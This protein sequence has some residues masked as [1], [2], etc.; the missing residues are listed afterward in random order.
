MADISGT[1]L[2]APVVPFTTEDSYPTHMAQ[3]GKGG[4]RSVQTKAELATIPS[5]RLE[6][7]MVA[8]VITEHTPYVYDGSDWKALV[9]EMDLSKVATEATLIAG[10]AS[11]EEKIENSL[12]NEVASLATTLEQYC[13][14][15]HPNLFKPDGMGVWY[16][17]TGELVDG[18]GYKCRAVHNTTGVPNYISVHISTDGATAFILQN[19]V[20]TTESYPISKE[21]IKTVSLTAILD[22]VGNIQ[23]DKSDLAK[24]GENQEATNSAILVEMLKLSSKVLNT[25]AVLTELDNGKKEMVASLATKNVQSS[26]DKTLSAIASDVRSIAQSPIYIDGGEM[27]EKQLFGAPTDKT[28]AYEQPNAP[29]WNLSQVMVNILSDG[30]FLEYGGIVLCEYDK[31]VTSQ[32]FEGASAGGLYFTSEGKIQEAL[33]EYIWD[34]F[35]NGKANRWVAIFNKKEFVNITFTTIANTPLSIHIGRKVGLLTTTQAGTQIREIICTEGNEYTLTLA[36]TSFSEQ[37]AFEGI[38]NVTQQIIPSNGGSSTRVIR[39]GVGDVNVQTQDGMIHFNAKG[40]AKSIIFSRLGK[41]TGKLLAVSAYSGSSTTISY[42]QFP[43]GYIFKGECIF[44]QFCVGLLGE[45][46]MTV[47][48]LKEITGGSLIYNQNSVINVGLEYLNIPDLEVLGTTA[49]IIRGYTNYQGGTYKVLKKI[50]IPK[51]RQANVVF[52]V[53]LSNN[54]LGVNSLIDVVV[55]AMETSF[56]LGTWRPLDVLADADKVVQLN[57]N[58]REHIAERITDRNGAEP[59]TITFH[60]QLR[61]AL[62]EETEQSFAAKNWNVAPAKTVTE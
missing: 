61:D 17:F 15:E 27:Y 7:G 2:V 25:E 1:N 53:P 52:T 44:Y 11:I 32:M 9:I 23:L 43:N 58:I 45:S 33:E 59:L 60:Q 12:P 40:A 30:R 8:Y 36:Q 54:T 16:V 47:K 50:S 29:L 3:Y 37:I 26:T 31:S 39:L 55:G 24:Q 21:N 51:L 34:D 35:D 6:V 14:G 13:P 20:E 62:T 46:T 49:N 22:A 10:I 4:W 48:G 5:Q 42:I 28:N 41:V 56:S 18:G 19:G 38:G 57:K